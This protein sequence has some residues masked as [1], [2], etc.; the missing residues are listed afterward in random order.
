M[1]TND[2]AERKLTFCLLTD[3]RGKEEKQRDFHLLPPLGI[4]KGSQEPFLTLGPV[5]LG[6]ARMPESAM[7][8]T[9]ETPRLFFW[10]THFGYCLP[11]A[12]S[13]LYIPSADL[14]PLQHCPVS[15]IGPE[16][17]RVVM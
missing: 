14:S 17:E 4:L 10:V 8:N 11:A 16:G 9:W 12:S 7:E 5:Y 13:S 2:C 6:G 15:P 3:L 1:N